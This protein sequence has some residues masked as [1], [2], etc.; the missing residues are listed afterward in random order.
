M[1]KSRA[2]LF[3]AVLMTVAMAGTAMAGSSVS[4]MQGMQTS[5]QSAVFASFLAYVPNEDPSMAIDSAISVSNVL[6]APEGVDAAGGAYEG[7]N[8]MGTVEIYLYMGGMMA[9]HETDMMLGPG[10][11]YTVFLSEVL[12]AAGHE[13]SFVGYAWIV[14]NFDGIAG[15]RKVFGQGFDQSGDLSPSVDHNGGGI[16]VMMM[17]MD[18]MDME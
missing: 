12:D 5:E 2:M 11:T 10:M 13:G 17:D 14:G 9:M 15:T 8:T 3:S 7:S 18:D 1:N 4:F 16:K 6:M